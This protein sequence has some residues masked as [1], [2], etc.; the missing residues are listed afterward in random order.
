MHRQYAVVVC[1]LRGIC[2]KPNRVVHGGFIYSIID[3]DKDISVII[4]K[5][6][7]TNYC[8]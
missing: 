6:I 1:G 3:R 7:L 8:D 4:M 2:E 5:R